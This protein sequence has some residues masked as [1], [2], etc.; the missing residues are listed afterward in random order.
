MLKNPLVDAVTEV[1]QTRHQAQVVARQTFPGIALPD[2][3][4]LTMDT[5]TFRIE[6][7]KRL[8]VQQAFEVQIRTLTD[9]FQLETKG[10]LMA[11][12]PVNSR[13]LRSTW[14]PSRVNVKRG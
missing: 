7:Q 3:I 1:G 9:Q 13:T 11:S 14:A 12:L 5:G 10:W 4:N 6:A 8:T 2:L